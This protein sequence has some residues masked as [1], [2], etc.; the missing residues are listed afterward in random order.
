[1]SDMDFVVSRLSRL[2]LLAAAVTVGA[3]CG[4]GIAEGPDAMGNP[5]A[6]GL[7]DAMV[8]DA[9]PDAEPGVDAGPN[10][11]NISGAAQQVHVTPAGETLIDVDFSTAVVQALVPDET[12]FTTHVGTGGDGTFTIEDVPE[13]EY[14]LRINADYY[15]TDSSAVTL[16]RYV[17]GRYD[18]AT[19]TMPT[20]MSFDVDSMPAW[21]A[22]D[23]LFWFD[24]GSGAYFP[25]MEYSI[26]PSPMTGT[27]D[28]ETSVDYAMAPT[29]RLVN[30]GEGDEPILSVLS[31]D[32]IAQDGIGWVGSTIATFSPDTLVMADGQAASATGSF[33]TATLDQQLALDWRVSEFLAQA[34]AAH[35]AADPTDYFWFSIRAMA[36]GSE[37]GPFG[38]A[39]EL[40]TAYPTVGRDTDISHT[41]DYARPFNWDTHG[42][43]NVEFYAPLALPGRNAITTP[44][45][46]VY[47]A[48]VLSD[49][50][51]NGLAPVVGPPRDLLLDDQD[52]TA[53]RDG[54]G[55]NPVL[56]W[57]A[58]DLG[59]PAMYRVEV[60]RLATSGASGSRAVRVARIWTNDTS[61]KIP[62]G[63]LTNGEYYF[64]RVVAMQSPGLTIASSPFTYT[65]P[66]GEAV[67]VTS[68][69]S[70]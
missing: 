17:V 22:A 67:A 43:T 44:A 66:Y 58:P 64:F 10:L 42:V 50:A 55:A 32:N 46:F 48:D 45:G 70:P 15:V 11:R 53:E 21:D 41:L 62:P 54:I 31:W 16:S 57:T 61:L 26:S 63:L 36:A 24:P 9:G 7:P 6:M 5:D 20:T 52:A 1:M 3:A 28:L 33:T 68:R 23:Q 4:D 30:T 51:T 56:S 14:I 49:I 29:P 37:H 2:M 38:T 18:A 69:I 47:T 34:S 8:A 65:F 35:P 12:G 39:Y 60:F 40:L 25:A 59:N 19:A 13:G 27:T